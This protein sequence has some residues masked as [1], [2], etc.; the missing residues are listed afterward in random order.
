MASAARC[1]LFFLQALCEIKER[2]RRRP[3]CH[4]RA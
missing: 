2:D 1:A 3:A 4:N